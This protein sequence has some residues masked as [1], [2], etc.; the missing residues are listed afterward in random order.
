MLNA[1]ISVGLGVVSGIATS[2]VVWGFIRL[3]KDFVL[4]WYQT[5]VYRGANVGGSWLGFWEKNETVDSHGTEEDDESPYAIA[6]P[7]FEIKITQNGH[8]I[9]GKITVF[10]TLENERNQKSF[11]VHGIFKDGNLIFTYT[12][13][14]LSRLGFGTFLLK[15]V[16]DATKLTGVCTYI[17]SGHGEIAEIWISAFRKNSSFDHQHGL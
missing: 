8:D 2:L 1:W 15:L 17:D 7:D 3:I 14:D 11:V 12:P 5:V 13:D 9:S 6:D 16:H 4:P 10:K